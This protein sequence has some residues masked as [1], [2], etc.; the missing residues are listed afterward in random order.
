MYEFRYRFKEMLLDAS[1]DTV[2]GI[3]GSRIHP[4]FES[5]WC[6]SRFSAYMTRH[7]SSAVFM[8]QG[9]FLSTGRI[10]VA[11]AAAGPSATNML[12][13]CASALKE[14]IPVLVVTGITS[15]K[16]RLKGTGQE[17]RRNEID[18]AE[19]FSQ[20][21]K[22]SAELMP[23]MDVDR[24]VA[25]ALFLAGSGIP[26]P[27]HLAVPVSLWQE[28]V[29]YRGEYPSGDDIYTSVEVPDRTIASLRRAVNM[30]RKPL[31][32]LGSSVDAGAIDAIERY[33]TAR[34][35]PVV[36]TPL[37]KNRY[38]ESAQNCFGHMGIASLM[39]TRKIVAEADAIAFFGCALH[40]AE[41][42]N[43]EPGLLA[44]A[45]LVQIIDQGSMVYN[46]YL[47]PDVI[48]VGDP[49][50][51]ATRLCTGDTDIADP[52]DWHLSSLAEQLAEERA[53]QPIFEKVPD[54]HGLHPAE[55]RKHFSAYLDE[56]DVV[57]SDIGAHM[58][59]SLRHIQLR[60]S[61]QF[62]LHLGFGAVTSGLLMAL[63][64]A[65]TRPERR[66]YSIVGDAAFHMMG[67]ELTTA[68]ENDWP[69]TVVV[70]NND[71][72]AM[73]W[74]DN[75]FRGFTNSFDLVVNKAH[76]SISNIAS[77]MGLTAWRAEDVDELGAVMEA[78]RCATGPCVVELR[79]DGKSVIPPLTEGGR[80][81]H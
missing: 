20:V 26:G 12:G 76:Y 63:G 70:E 55:W 80:R 75:I 17:T 19:M 5:V 13:A 53:C 45:T 67:T 24:Y 16:D 59:F 40:E 62:Y 65:A 25:K 41:A 3:P 49:G 38:P 39:T 56:D 2:F 10:A 18:V 4:F 79:V 61:N 54:S 81:A 57:F 71:M 6:D 27:V 31:F 8:A 44:P 52:F 46:S 15:V 22:F 34:Q 42:C 9:V 32:V 14:R 77:A 11:A 23:D 58:L 48:I 29:E 74:H 78:M 33:T 51:I 7:E 37:S 66:T 28:P 72:H 21:T 35:I 36:N 30:A 69:I 73:T 1:I 47:T 50:R 68:V 64:F 60:R 43:D